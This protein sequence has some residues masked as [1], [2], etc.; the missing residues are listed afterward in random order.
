MEPK[1]EPQPFEVV[2]FS[3]VAG[4]VRLVCAGFIVGMVAGAV[5]MFISWG[6]L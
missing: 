1:E 4:W 3:M 5:I 6:G 2:P